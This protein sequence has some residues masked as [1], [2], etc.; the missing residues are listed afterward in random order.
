ME[1]QTSPQKSGA[2]KR[3]AYT[4][5]NKCPV[6]GKRFKYLF[7]MN[8]HLKK[9]KICASQVVMPD[10]EE[11][12][13]THLD[14]TQENGQIVVIQQ[15]QHKCASCELNFPTSAALVEHNQ[16]CYKMEYR[17][18]ICSKRFK[19]EFGYNKHM[20]VEHGS[21]TGQNI[22]GSSAGGV[23]SNT[24]LG[25]KHNVAAIS[26]PKKVGIGKVEKNYGKLEYK[27]YTMSFK[28]NKCNKRFKEEF[29]LDKHM[30]VLHAEPGKKKPAPSTIVT[31]S[32]QTVHYVQ[33]N[34]AQPT[35]IQQPQSI[36]TKL[37]KL[38]TEYK[39]FKK[40]KLYKQLR[41]L[42]CPKLCCV[43]IAMPHLQRNTI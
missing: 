36:H 3:E 15:A 20:D 29:C 1:Q 13:S 5:P 8:E 11:E 14:L 39:W 43:A 16:R 40:F 18:N 7:C 32:P 35:V 6:C 9:S 21:R 41:Q 2:R 37:S 27:P 4:M 10:V 28:C 31:T 30:E 38:R 34:I 17:C 26:P 24:V 33:K 25:K 12:T 22:A 19:Y 42:K 23:G